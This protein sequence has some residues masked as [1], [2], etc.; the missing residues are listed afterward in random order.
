MAIAAGAPIVPVIV[1][2]ALPV[3]PKGTWRIRPGVVDIHFLEPVR[4]EGLTNADRGMLAR[5]VHDRMSEALTA[6]YAV[7]PDPASAADA[8]PSAV[9]TFAPH[10]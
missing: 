1:H 9:L 3:M 7:A 4:T 5:R 6:L 2:G 8:S 10:G